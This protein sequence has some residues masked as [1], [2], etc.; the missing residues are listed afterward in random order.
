MKKTNS[1]ISCIPYP[2]TPHAILLKERLFLFIPLL[3]SILVNEIV[4]HCTANSP[5]NHFI[6]DIQRNGLH[7]FLLCV[8]AQHIT[9]NSIHFNRKVNRCEK[10]NRMAEQRKKNPKRTFFINRDENEY[11]TYESKM[12]YISHFLTSIHDTQNASSSPIK[13]VTQSVFSMYGKFVVKS[14]SIFTHFS[15]IYTTTYP[16]KYVEREQYPIV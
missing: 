1:S 2:Y 8:T 16:V 11:Q 13:R 12:A 3:L 5:H 7:Q 4:W 10:T 9:R 14:S 15:S 6:A